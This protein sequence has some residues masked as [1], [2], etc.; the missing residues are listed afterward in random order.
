M[1]VRVDESGQDER[2]G[3]G[4]DKLCLRVFVPQKL[5][6]SALQNALIKDK[7][8]I[9]KYSKALITQKNI[10]RPYDKHNLSLK[11]K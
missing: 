9:F 5:E 3:R 2:V 11:F 8:L 4:L 1:R 6:F 10:A 7:S